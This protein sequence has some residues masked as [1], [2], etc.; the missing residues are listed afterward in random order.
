MALN[1]AFRIAEERFG[2][3][4]DIGG[5]DLVNADF[6]GCGDDNRM[7]LTPG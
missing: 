1:G 2:R 6:C 7:A 5:L 4:P 3:E